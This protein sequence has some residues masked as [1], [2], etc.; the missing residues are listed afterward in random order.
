MSRKFLPVDLSKV[1]TYPLV[2]RASKVSLAGFADLA[3]AGASFGHFLNGLPDI[4]TG[5]DFRHLVHDLAEAVRQDK[6]VAVGMGGH[7]I[8]C[9][10][11]PVLIDLMRR[12][13]ISAIAMNGSTSIHD[14]EIAMHGQTSEDVAEGLKDG[15]FGMAQDTGE[16]INDAI[17]H[18]RGG[19]GYLIGKKIVETKQPHRQYSL[20][21]AAYELGIP[22]TVHVAIGTDIVQ[23]QP[24]ANGQNIGRASF[25]DFRIFCSVVSSL[26]GGAYLNL[27]SAVIMPEVFL[28]ALTVARNLGHPVDHFV[29]ANFDMIQH[30]RPRVNVVQRPTMQGG[31]GY[32]FTGHHEIMIPLLAQTLSEALGDRVET[33]DYKILTHEK[34]VQ[35]RERLRD[36]R[37]KVVFTNGCFDILHRGHVTY[38]QKARS[39]GDVLILGLNNDASVRRLKGEGRPIQPLEDRATVLAGLECIDYIVPFAEDTP[40]DLIKALKPDLLVKGGDYQLDEIVGRKE[41]EEAGGQVTTISLVEGRS[42]TTLVN[43]IRQVGGQI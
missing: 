22:A 19:Y 39:L 38:L 36:I 5:A 21:S 24:T 28:K 2:K 37:A 29:T 27:G 41:V 26:E 6:T 25:E 14:V 10:L 12:G 17:H 32:H 40:I 1:T 20:L 11:S 31:K 30:Y 42:T 16:L 15:S 8:K 4:L 43:K 23:Q 35:I 13:W 33:S 9:G 34:A 7:V 18:D 3:R